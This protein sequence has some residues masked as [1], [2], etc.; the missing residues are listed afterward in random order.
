MYIKFDHFDQDGDSDKTICFF[1]P[2]ITIT[3]AP[4]SSFPAST[5]Y[6]S[7]LY[8]YSRAHFS[9]SLLLHPSF[10]SLSTE[11]IQVSVRFVFFL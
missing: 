8:S 10:S 3:D 6:F 2:W 5:K 11:H 7:D 4:V 1:S 9:T